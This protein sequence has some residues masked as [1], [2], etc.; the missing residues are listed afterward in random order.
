MN[1]DDNANVILVIGIILGVISLLC[2]V[3]IMISNRAKRRNESFEPIEPTPN[4]DRDREDTLIDD[5]IID[6]DGS[7]GGLKKTIIS[8]DDTVVPKKEPEKP[9]SDSDIMKLIYSFPEDSAWISCPNCGT[10]ARA[11]DPYC[12][13][14]AQPL[15]GS[16][17]R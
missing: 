7:G 10:E 6:G 13:V 8:K 4:D 14:C 16:Y 15:K 2:L 3:G 17:S 5:K 12:T 11:G 9:D 1:F